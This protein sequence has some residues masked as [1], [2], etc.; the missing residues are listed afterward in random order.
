MPQDRLRFLATIS[1]KNAV[2]QNPRLL[3]VCENFSG[4]KTTNIERLLNTS[5]VPIFSQIATITH[6]TL[7][8][9]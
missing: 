6:V 2:A 8:T 5:S 9:V 3:R 7:N 1:T 4:A